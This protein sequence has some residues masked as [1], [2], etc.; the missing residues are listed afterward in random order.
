M[1][2]NYFDIYRR[3][4]RL[5]IN[6][7]WDGSE[8]GTGRLEGKRGTSNRALLRNRLPSF[9]WRTIRFTPGSR[10]T[11]GREFQRSYRTLCESQ[12]DQKGAEEESRRKE[13]R[14]HSVFHSHSEESSQ[15]V[16]RF[17]WENR[18]IYQT[19]EFINFSS[20]FL[21]QNTSSPDCCAKI[22]RRHDLNI[23]VIRVHL[24]KAPFECS[25]VR[26]SEGFLQLWRP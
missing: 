13:E 20:H 7:R 25:E 10:S 11:F 6:W 21:I 3:R 24:W 23:H 14:M 4:R 19:E 16:R 17:H 8:N 26:M 9:Q 22:R 5:E 15:E 2:Q 18:N 1:F 12:P